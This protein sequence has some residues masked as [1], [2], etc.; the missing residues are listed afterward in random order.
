MTQNSTLYSQL[1]KDFQQLDYQ[2]KRQKLITIIN[3][4]QGDLDHAEEI[5]TLI[6]NKGVS[7][8][9]FDNLYE[10]I[11]KTLAEDFEERKAE[12]LNTVQQKFQAFIV[13]QEIIR[14]QEIKEAESLFDDLLLDDIK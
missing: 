10:I 5:L 2:D 11:M 9:Y 13:Q 3:A 8:G 1:W 7:E 4:L 12:H 6:N 14:K